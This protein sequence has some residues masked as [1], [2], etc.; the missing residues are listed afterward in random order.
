VFEDFSRIGR[1]LKD[2][3]QTLDEII[4]AGVKM[5]NSY[6]YDFEIINSIWY[7]NLDC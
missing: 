4:E 5:E 1:T 7:F 2:T 3:I 6:T